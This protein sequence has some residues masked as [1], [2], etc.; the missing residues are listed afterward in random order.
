[1]KVVQINSECGRG[2]TGKIAVAISE[3]LS[4]KGIENYI[5]YSGNHK[6]DYENSWM[7]A[8]KYS[9]R[10]HQI[11]SRIFGDQGFHSSLATRRLVKKLGE[12][13]PDV[14]LMHNL[15]GYYL[16]IGIFFDFLAGFKGKVY[17]T[18]HD[19]W[20]FTGHCTHFMNVGCEKWKTGCYECPQKRKYPYSWFFDRSKTL[21]EQ[22]KQLVSKV[23][24]LTIITPSIWLA[25]TVKASYINNRPVVVV[26]NGI[27]LDVF[28]PTESDFKDRYRIQDKMIILG[29]AAVWSN[30]KGLDMLIRL[31][32]EL[33]ESIYQ[34]VLVGT[35]DTVDRYL[36]DNILS[37]H[38]TQNQKELAE[39][40]SAADVF[41]NPTREDN[42]PSV[43]MEAIACGTPVVAF[44]TG[45]CKESI[46]E[47]CGVIVQSK[48]YGELKGAV[49]SV[50]GMKGKLSQKCIDSSK[51]FDQR[52]CFEKYVDLICS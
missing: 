8:K 47:G 17:W 39:I 36:P 21:Y 40:Y 27:N 50:I 6:S 42:Y 44:D 1:M 30:A 35:D 11:L 28:K 46:D 4:S 26:N 13:N 22:K 32:Q 16:H 24:D 25:D 45:G 52:I 9:I 23:D 12:T 41:V 38:R 2:S 7:I 14:I 43:N 5:F 37:I 33:D 15:H 29:V 51:R 10:L 3:Q 20:A 34:I 19:C 49:L 18:L 48:S 31:S